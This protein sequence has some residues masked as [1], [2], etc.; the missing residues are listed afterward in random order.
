MPLPD[1]TLDKLLRDLGLGE[2]GATSPRT[3]VAP[4]PDWAGLAADVD[5]EYGEP[6]QQRSRPQQARVLSALERKAVR[7][8]REQPADDEFTVPPPGEPKRATQKMAAKLAALVTAKAGTL[9]DQARHA[10]TSRLLGRDIASWHE[11]T[12]T[13][14][15]RLIQQLEDLPDNPLPPVDT[16]GTPPAATP[17]PRNGDGPPVDLRPTKGPAAEELDR[18][19]RFK[20]QIG[21]TDDA[22]TLNPLYG[23][24]VETRDA[25]Q[26]TPDQFAELEHLVD[27]RY[28]HLTQGP[29]V[30]SD[31]WSHRKLDEMAGAPR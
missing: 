24:L 26:I 16:T 20:A 13:D 17:N 12:F 19:D 1:F 18:V 10:F 23:T 9:D 27:A 8:Q 4:A 29:A 25:G 7:E 2:Q 22:T 5:A 6:A 11:L 21:Q 31:S 30:N 3:Y 14:V 28:E 15:H